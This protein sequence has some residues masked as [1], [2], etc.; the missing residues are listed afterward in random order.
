MR[1]AILKTK[2][3]LKAS[4]ATTPKKSA[5][6]K[7]RRIEQPQGGVDIILSSGFLAF[8]SHSGF[9]QAVED[10]G[11]PVRSIVGTSSGALVGSMKAA[12]YSAKEIATEFSRLPPIQRVRPSHRPWE[13]ILSLDPV[14]TILQELLPQTFEELQLQMAATVVD[15]YGQHRLVD[16]G[17]LAPAVVASAAVPLLFQ[18]VDIPGIECGPFLDGG[19]ADRIGLDLWRSERVS[20][21]PP[22]ATIVHLIGRSSPFSGPDKT[23]SIA[24]ASIVY[25]PRSGASLWDLSGFDE[26]FEQ[27]RRRAMPVLEEVIVRKA[28]ILDYV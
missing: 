21:V 17:I 16:S 23:D 25:S 11:L 3:L 12:G 5:D 26:Q 18:R 20:E 10:V 7:A 4:S 13:G 6:S 8:A 19:L 28:Q 22:S 1:L 14:I 27:A 15:S 9:L 24:D 2:S